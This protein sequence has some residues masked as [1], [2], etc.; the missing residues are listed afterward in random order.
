LNAF[1]GKNKLKNDD[2]GKSGHQVKSIQKKLLTA[3]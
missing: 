1:A 2:T 3:R